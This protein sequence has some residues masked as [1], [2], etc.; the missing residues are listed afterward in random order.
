[1]LGDNRLGPNFVGHGKLKILGKNSSVV[2][3]GLFEDSLIRIGGEE[4]K[5]SK[6][7]LKNCNKTKY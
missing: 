6:N 2:K 5:R 1:M 7:T 3:I 4:G